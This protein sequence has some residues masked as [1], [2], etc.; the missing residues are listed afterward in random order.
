MTA[1]RVLQSLANLNHSAAEAMIIGLYKAIDRERIQFDFL[2]D[3]QS[4]PYAFA[5]EVERLGGRMFTVP[6]FNGKNVRTYRKAV[7][8]LLQEHPEWQLVHMHNSSTAML[9][10]D[11]VKKQQ[12][13]PIVHAHFNRRPRDFRSFTQELLRSRIKYHTNYLLARSQEA[14]M[15]TFKVEKEAFNIIKN[16]IET[17]KFVFNQTVREQ[18][19]AELDIEEELTVLGHVGGMSEDKNHLFLI[20]IFRWHLQFNPKSLLL[21]IGSGELEKRIRNKVTFY[22]LET[23]VK[24]LGVRDDVSEL[25]QAMDIFVFPSLF[26]EFPV[27]LVEAQAAGLP[28]VASDAMTREV[29]ITDLITFIPL[30]KNPFYWAQTIDKQS[31]LF[32]D[33]KREEI[34][35]AGYDIKE[36]AKELENYY[37][38]IVEEVDR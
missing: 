23:K 26:E 18:K 31:L 14:G 16:A 24:F 12:M 6:K 25:L 9:V 7:K 22:N 2:V 5:Q 32:R 3:K 28:V 30:D 38:N 21:L 13:K 17:E 15:N 19:R 1:I 11:I 29:E 36:A 37:L 33:N 4:D 27:T 35:A 20:D 10:M 34:L 8:R